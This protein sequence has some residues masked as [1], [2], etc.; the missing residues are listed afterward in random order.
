[1]VTRPSGW[2]P[3]AL[4][5]LAL[6]LGC[7]VDGRVLT[8]TD[9]ESGQSS[10]AAAGR[11]AS[12]GTG[13]AS[14]GKGGSA[15]KGGSSSAGTGGSGATGDYLDCDGDPVAVNL[16]VV[17]A[18]VLQTSCHPYLP[19]TSISQCVTYQTLRAFPQGDCG[20]SSDS[21]ADFRACAKYGYYD[22]AG[23]TGTVEALCEGNVGVVCS[24]EF[25]SEFDCDPGTTCEVV[26]TADGNSAGCR[27]PDSCG[28]PDGTAAC[29]GNLHYSCRGGVRYGGDCAVSGAMC[30]LDEAT[31]STGC[32]YVTPPCSPPD[33]VECGAANRIDI[34]TTAGTTAHYECAGG[35]GCTLD[36]DGSAW[37]VAPGCTPD[38]ACSESCSGTELTLCYGSI[39]VTVDCRD[40]GLSQCIESTLSDDTTT[41]YRCAV[42]E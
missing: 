32:Y 33:T 21:C 30:R 12:G 17:K 11:G 35:L 19:S 8:E 10:G 5:T 40:Y 26:A 9:G 4:W 39:P 7:S 24:G 16:D 3:T 29:D 28:E 25:S 41:I 31:G 23:C 42:P 2:T 27:F 1:V 18:C 6:A 37:C 14:G 20:T 15:G 38:D 36:G 34:C 13:G 22:G